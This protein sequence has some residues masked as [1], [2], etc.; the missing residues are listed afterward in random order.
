MAKR[1]QELYTS[2]EKA[3]TW[4]N[5][6]SLEHANFTEKRV[7]GKWN[8]C[9]HEFNVKQSNNNT[10]KIC[11]ETTV[12]LQDYIKGLN[13]KVICIDDIRSVLTN[14]HKFRVIYTDE[15]TYLSK[16]PSFEPTEK[17][18]NESLFEWQ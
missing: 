7:F 4:Y 10:A 18:T 13:R 9:F 12:K 3:E 6:G 15:E 5:L 2:F 16:D 11:S 1:A 8:D 17:L 14:K